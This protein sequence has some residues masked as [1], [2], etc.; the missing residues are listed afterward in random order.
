VV[1]FVSGSVIAITDMLCSDVQ[2]NGFVVKFIDH[3]Q[4]V[5]FRPSCFLGKLSAATRNFPAPPYY[6]K[7]AVFAYRRP[8]SFISFIS[9]ELYIHL[10]RYATNTKQVTL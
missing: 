7:R 8:M 9:C 4:M 6:S 5:I 3:I 10:K 1:W 2:E